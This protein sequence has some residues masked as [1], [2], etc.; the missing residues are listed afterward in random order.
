MRGDG[1]CIEKEEKVQRE[2]TTWD[3]AFVL[4]KKPPKA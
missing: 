3:Q 2:L 1:S 4:P